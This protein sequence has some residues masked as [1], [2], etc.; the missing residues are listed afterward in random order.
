[1]DQQTWARLAAQTLVAMDR[2]WKRD[3]EPGILAQ[4]QGAHG[5]SGSAPAATPS[6]KPDDQAGFYDAMTLGALRARLR[7]LSVEQLEQLRIYESAHANRQPV[8]A[9]LDHRIANLAAKQVQQEG[10]TTDKE[11]EEFCQLVGGFYVDQDHEGT[12][13]TG[14]LEG[15]PPAMSERRRSGDRGSG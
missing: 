4:A 12:R 7:A 11:F 5:D 13:T 9:M 15:A 1:M 14:D 10:Q 3:T 8:I 6:A 2:H